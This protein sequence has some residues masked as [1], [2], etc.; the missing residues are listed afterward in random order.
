M[1]ERIKGKVKWFNAV[2]GYG[3]ISTEDGKDIFF[4]FSA[5]QGYGFQ[6][7]MEGQAVEFTIE[8]GPKDLQASNV[9]LSELAGDPTTDAPPPDAKKKKRK[10]K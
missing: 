2:K 6:P 1:T 8:Q 7:P 4:H 9:C 5:V 10:G 3:F